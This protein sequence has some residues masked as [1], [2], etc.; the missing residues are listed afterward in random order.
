MT[1]CDKNSSPCIVGLF[2]GG[3]KFTICRPS[4]LF[5]FSTMTARVTTV[6]INSVNAFVRR[7]V[8]HI[9]IKVFKFE[10]S[11]AYSYSST[12]VIN[13]V[14]MFFIKAS[15]SYMA[16][17]SVNLSFPHTVCTIDLPYSFFMKATARLRIT[18]FQR[19]RTGD[20]FTPAIAFTRPEYS[21]VSL[22]NFTNDNKTPESLANKIYR[23]SHAL[24]RNKKPVA[25]GLVSRKTKTL[26]AIKSQNEFVFTNESEAKLGNLFL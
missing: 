1:M 22:A 14:R 23:S 20:L 3:R 8:A 13:I 24:Y 2:F 25:F 21:S 9:L 19:I 5:A 16:P 10:P 17:N 15:S 4:F 6:V 11:G 18:P 12:S 7:A 26:R